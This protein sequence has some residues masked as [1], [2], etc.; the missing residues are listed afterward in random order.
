[1][2]I[3]TSSKA[4]PVSECL[5]ELVARVQAS[6][7]IVLK[8]P[9]GA[10]KTTGV[11]PALLDAGIAESGRILLIQPRRMAAR[12]AAKRL[13]SLRGGSLGAEIGYHVRYDKCFGA[14]TKL[15]AMTTGV[16][17]RRLSADPLLDG[18]A[19][20]LLDEFHERSIEMDLALGMLQR[21]R[22]AFRPELRLLVMSA[23]LEPAPIV[24]FLGDA[25][26]IESRGRSYPV[27]IEYSPAMSREPVERQIASVLPGILDRTAGHVLVFLPG[28]GEIRRVHRML[29]SHGLNSRDEG[30]GTTTVLDLFGDQTPE[31]QDAVLAA[32]AQRK[33]IL[34]TNVAE[35]S[36]T[37]PGIT[38][39]I[40]T[41]TARVMQYDNRVGLPRLQLQPISQA[42]ADQRAGRAGRTER[43]EC[44]RLWPLALHRT[45]RPLDLPEI[46]RCDFSAAMLTLAGWGERDVLEFPW[47]DAPPSASV[48]GARSLLERLDAID[49][50]GGITQLGRMML[51]L[52][53]TP[54]LARFMIEATRMGVEEDASLAAAML[55]ERDPF[56]GETLPAIGDSTGCD[57]Y[58]R[59]ERLRAFEM[60]DKRSVVHTRAARQVMQAAKQIRRELAS[61]S[62]DWREPPESDQQHLATATKSERFKRA[63]LT[64]FP[65]RLARRRDGDNG[66]GIMVGGR[67]VRLDGQSRARSGE[68]FLCIDIDSKGVEATVRMASAVDSSWLD[69][70]HIRQV[71]EPFFDESLAGVVARRR[72]YFHDLLLAES[73]I[74]CEPGAE[75]ASQLAGQARKNLPRI[76]S[77]K[78]EPLFEFIS[79]VRFLQAQMPRLELPLLDD[80]AIDE[81]LVELCQTR[82]SFAELASAPWLDHARG[83]Y[84]GKQ[85]EL[86]ERHAPSRMILPKGNTVAIRYAD[87][88]PPTMEVRIQEVFGWRDTPR[89]AGGSVAIQLHLLGPNDRPQQITEDLASFWRETYSQVRKELRRRYPKHHWPED[90]LT[91]PPTRNGLKPRP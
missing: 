30:S 50:D 31:D 73:P 19:C 34:S 35:T 52:P 56:R 40:D 36:V 59:V 24:N 88:K 47:L 43:G 15:I 26:S 14:A 54:R 90:P 5:G 69:A 67:G 62:R 17:L 51:A 75:V 80:T 71:D 53:L 57:V 49:A 46:C 21:I 22:S 63:L 1:M 28:V 37:I 45:R 44:Y 2:P 12:G 32:T 68:L 33:I 18:V 4:L 3:V 38:A 9:P 42:S 77:K 89:I 39:V 11:P 8:A 87:G 76:L 61:L 55:S 60:G 74:R 81:V 78:Q 13:S 27:A 70:G 66:R 20:V 41:G 7:P 84:D 6:I 64:A 58:D 16:L 82:T 29:E 25:V 91:A 86:I 65:D 79:R 83:R 10:G 23:T 48:T 85:L 72:R